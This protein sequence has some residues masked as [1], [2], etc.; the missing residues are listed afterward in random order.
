MEYGDLKV[1][2]SGKLTT[3]SSSDEYTAPSDTTTQ[4][5]MIWI[6]NAA[7]SG[8]VNI[9]TTFGLSSSVVFFH[10]LIG[11][12]VSYEISPKVPFILEDGETLSFEAQSAN[13]FDFIV[14]GRESV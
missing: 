1:L 10:E 4:I 5:S 2:A 6:H 3:T 8:S 7:L 12:N 14:I 11:Q 9:K 13:I